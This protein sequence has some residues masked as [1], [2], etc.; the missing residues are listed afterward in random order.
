[1]GIINQYFVAIPRE[2]AVLRLDLWSEATRNPAIA[3]M[4]ARFDEE[5]RGFFIDTIS[6]LATSPDC[7]PA[8]LYEALDGLM[9]GMSSTAPCGRTT[10]RPR[11]P[12]G[13]EPCSMR[14]W[15]AA[16][17]PVPTPIPI[18]LRRPADEPRPQAGRT[19]DPGPR[20]RAAGLARAR[21]DRT[22]QARTHHDH[23]TKTAPA[24]APPRAS[25]IPAVSVVEAA[26]RE[27][28]ETVVVTGTLVPRDEIL[29]TPEIDGYRITEVLVEEGCASSGAK[30]WPVCRAT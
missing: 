14:A 17:R 10:T 9:R 7:D 21:R 1:M 5:G 24:L 13:C 25:L 27:I 12:L 19:R 18:A 8:A 15:P 26:R 6:A 23:T 16:C 28:V 2:T 4:T 30:S 22:H 20:P 11:P 3:A 29:V